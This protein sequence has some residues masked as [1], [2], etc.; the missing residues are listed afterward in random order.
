ML[1]II[2]KNSV[3]HESI[4]ENNFCTMYNTANELNPTTEKQSKKEQFNM[5]IECSYFGYK[6]TQ[7]SC[8]PDTIFTM[9][10]YMHKFHFTLNNQEQF[11]LH[12]PVLINVINDTNGCNTNL[13]RNYW[14]S[15]I[16]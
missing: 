8:A 14:H 16:H 10:H 7:N 9:I 2:K 11:C 12:F 5:N 6:W 4:A 1:Q 3:Q 13:N 15:L